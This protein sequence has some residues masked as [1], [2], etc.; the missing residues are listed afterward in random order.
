MSNDGMWIVLWHLSLQIQ[1]LNKILFLSS[2]EEALSSEEEKVPTEAIVVDEAVLVVAGEVGAATVEAVRV[3][4]GREVVAVSVAL[5]Q[6]RR[7]DS[8]A[9]AALVVG[10]EV[11][12]AK[13]AKRDTVAVGTKESA[14]VELWLDLAL[15]GER[16]MPATEEAGA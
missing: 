12:R 15:Q 1:Y 10:L 6:A 7:A 16:G 2:E 3:A 4:E 13:L 8:S 9:E 14:E 11:G 5:P